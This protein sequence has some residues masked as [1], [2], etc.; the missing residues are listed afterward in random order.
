MAS[1]KKISLRKQLDL[2]HYQ[3]ALQFAEKFALADKAEFLN[4][5]NERAMFEQQSL[6]QENLKKSPLVRVGILLL[7]TIFFLCGGLY[8]QTGRYSVVEQG[9][10]V[11]EEFQQVR[12]EQ[13]I[14]ARND[15]YILNLQNRLRENPNDGDLWFE[16]AQAYSLNNEFEH[17]ML[18]YQNAQIVQGKTAAILGGMATVE[19]YRNR[20]QFTPQIKQW[21]EEALNKDRYESTALLLLASDAYLR[22]DFREA[23]SHWENV[24]NSENSAIDKREVIR[25]IQAAKA[26]L[27]HEKF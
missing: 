5:I 10:A 2:E 12:T 21:I 22:N 18:C 4:E 27:N 1:E 7:V 15:G 14:E 3:Q 13:H 6:V 16:L 26:R 23:I 20:H 19:Y 24:L 8:W 11:F 25:S 9:I 17:A